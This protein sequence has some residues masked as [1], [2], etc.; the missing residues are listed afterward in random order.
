M[1]RKQI[2]NRIGVGARVLII[3]PRRDGGKTRMRLQLLRRWGWR[4]CCTI[5]AP[6]SGSL[7]T[8]AEQWLKD[9]EHNPKRFRRG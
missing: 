3:F 9:Y 4:T 5:E 6:R 7:H 2:V 1:E 8:L